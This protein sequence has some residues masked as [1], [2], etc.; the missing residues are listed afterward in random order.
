MGSP[1]QG[2]PSYEFPTIFLEVLT[3][4]LPLK[5]LYGGV[6]ALTVLRAESDLGQYI[7]V[8]TYILD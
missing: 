2:N 3:S 5:F 4:G 1:N 7:Y 8:Y 6:A